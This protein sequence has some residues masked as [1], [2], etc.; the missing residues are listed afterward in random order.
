MR[1]QGTYFERDQGVIVLCAMFLVSCIFFN[2]CLYFSYYMAGYVLRPCTYVRKYLKKKIIEMLGEL[3]IQITLHQIIHSTYPFILYTSV[4]LSS[5]SL[6]LSMPYKVPPASENLSRCT[7]VFFS[8]EFI[9][10]KHMMY[11]FHLSFTCFIFYKLCLHEH[12][13]YMLL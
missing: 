5:F 8:T 1:H 12:L 11:L 13:F 3:G 7:A 2:K 9:I 6:S 10:T 4:V